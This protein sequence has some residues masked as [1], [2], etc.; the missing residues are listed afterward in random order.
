MSLQPFDLFSQWLVEMN[1]MTWGSLLLVYCYCQLDSFDL[2][3]SS[4]RLVF[5]FL[6]SI[7]APIPSY[8]SIFWCITLRD[9]MPNS[10]SPIII[11]NMLLNIWRQNFSKRANMFVSKDDVSELLK[12]T[13]IQWFGKEIR[14]HWQRWTMSDVNLQ[15]LGLIFNPK[16][17]DVDMSW[18]LSS[19][20]PLICF[21]LNSTLIVLLEYTF[22]HFVTMCL[23]EQF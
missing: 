14:Q 1:R 20:H 23:H 19:R 8:T 11:S 21:H 16:I 22:I 9:I 10:K 15:C 5:I 7:P 12:Q 2:M 18:L 3:N 6:P 4:L 13:T 17:S